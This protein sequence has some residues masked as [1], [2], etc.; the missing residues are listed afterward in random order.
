MGDCI[1]AIH[2]SSDSVDTGFFRFILDSIMPWMVFEVGGQ[3]EMN[4]YSSSF[5]LNILEI[6]N[7]FAEDRSFVDGRVERVAIIR[8]ICSCSDFP[9]NNGSKSNQNKIP[10]SYHH[11]A[12]PREYTQ[13]ST[14]QSLPYTHTPAKPQET[15][16]SGIVY[17]HTESLYGNTR[18]QS[19]LL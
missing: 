13:D 5:F 11:K 17:T 15:D 16:K 1:S 7:W 2:S 10:F 3:G 4:V 9:G 18:I 19:R 12:I 6:F 8:E 14:Y